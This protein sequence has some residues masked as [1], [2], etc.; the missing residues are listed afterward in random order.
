M[1]YTTCSLCSALIDWVNWLE[2]ALEVSIQ[3]TRRRSNLS[4]AEEVLMQYQ[5]QNIHVSSPV[6]ISQLE[7][8]IEKHMSWLDHVHLFFALNFRDRSWDLLLQLK[9]IYLVC[10][11]FFSFLQV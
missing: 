1:V 7:T 8:A 4:D 5:L 11:V 2:R 9:V 3:S 6:M 10:C